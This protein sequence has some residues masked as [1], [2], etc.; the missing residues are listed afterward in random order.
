MND[1]MTRETYGKSV[2]P[3]SL[4]LLARV[5]CRVLGTMLD[6]R[7]RLE[8]VYI[9]LVKFDSDLASLDQLVNWF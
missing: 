4:S 3:S 7:A 1:A 8:Y 9:I 5:G 6:A 2:L